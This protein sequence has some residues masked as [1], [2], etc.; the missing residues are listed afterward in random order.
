MACTHCHGPTI[1]QGANLESCTCCD[2]SQLR[3]PVEA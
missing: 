1:A 2:H 3:Q